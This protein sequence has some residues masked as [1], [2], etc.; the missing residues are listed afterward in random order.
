[1]RPGLPTRRRRTT[2]AA[3]RQDGERCSCR[4]VLSPLCPHVGGIA[5]TH[6]RRRRNTEHLLAALDS[7]ER[8]TAHTAC[9][10]FRVSAQWNINGRTNSAFSLNGRAERKNV[11]LPGL[12]IT[13]EPHLTGGER[14]SAAPSKLA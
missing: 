6:A 11:L 2:E 8:E 5:H 3:A 13:L 9:F 1:M 12:D 4:Y 10:V 14:A 7:R